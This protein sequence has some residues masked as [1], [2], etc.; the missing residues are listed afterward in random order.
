MEVPIE[1]SIT[2]NAKDPD[3][4]NHMTIGMRHIILLNLII[5]AITSFKILTVVLLHGPVYWDVT[6]VS[7]EC[8]AKDPQSSKLQELLNQG[9]AT[10]HKTCFFYAASC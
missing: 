5:L 1:H 10:Y 3:L 2:V 4:N 9:S 6:C 7:E 8:N